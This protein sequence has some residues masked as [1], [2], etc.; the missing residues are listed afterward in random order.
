MSP[1]GENG[2]WTPHGTARG[3]GWVVLTVLGAVN[4][5]CKMRGVCGGPLESGLMLLF[6][7]R[8][9]SGHVSLLRRKWCVC[10]WSERVEEWCLFFTILPCVALE[11]LK[12]LQHVHGCGSGSVRSTEYSTGNVSGPVGSGTEPPCRLS[13]CA[14]PVFQTVMEA[15]SL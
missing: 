5:N 4:V 13:G 10:A 6:A 9:T 3:K 14:C 7:P 15:S 8:L 11:S 2:H 12:L 1:A